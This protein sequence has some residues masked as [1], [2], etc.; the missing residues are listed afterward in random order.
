[1]R[2][3][4]IRLREPDDEG[5]PVTTLDQLRFNAAARATS[6]RDHN[7]VN[8]RRSWS[9][10][11]STVRWWPLNRMFG[12]AVRTAV[13]DPVRNGDIGFV[14]VAR[15]HWGTTYVTERAHGE[16]KTTGEWTRWLY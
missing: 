14:T 9:D 11:N 4:R 7:R 3:E 12:C 8:L 5:V 16:W 15:D 1:M 6:L 13:T 2:G 10:P